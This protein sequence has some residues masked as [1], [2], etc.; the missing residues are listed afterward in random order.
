MYHN[1]LASIA[2][3]AKNDKKAKVIALKIIAIA[4]PY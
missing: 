2:Y 3:I 1:I 4:E